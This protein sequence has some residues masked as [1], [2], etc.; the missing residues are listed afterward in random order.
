[1]VLTLLPT[2][3]LADGASG[4]SVFSGSGHEAMVATYTIDNDANVDY[5]ATLAEAVENVKGGGT[6]TL[7]TSVELKEKLVLPE[8][9]TFTLDLGKY[10]I[11][12][13]AG[14]VNAINLAKGGNVTITGTGKITGNYNGV[15]V[16]SGA[17]LTVNGAEIEATVY[18]GI[19]NEGTTIVDSG[20]LT[21]GTDGE[22]Y[23]NGI[24][25]NCGT[26]TV[27]GGTINKIYAENGGTA[28]ITGGTVNGRFYFE[29]TT[30]RVEGGSIKGDMQRGGEDEGITVT[31]G[32]F[33][34]KVFAKS[35]TGGTFN[36]ALTL[37]NYSN[38]KNFQNCTINGS[39]AWNRFSKA[40]M[41]ARAG[42]NIRFGENASVENEHYSINSEL[43][44]ID[45]DYLTLNIYACDGG[46]MEVR[47]DSTTG[48]GKTS[49]KNEKVEAGSKKTVNSA[50]VT[51][52]SGYKFDGWYLNGNKITDGV[53][54]DGSLTDYELTVTENTDLV[55]RFI[56]LDY[57]NKAAIKF[58]DSE[59]TLSSYDDW[60]LFTYA[61]TNL[62]YTF[63]GKTVKLDFT[64]K[65][66]N[67]AGKTY[68]VVGSNEHPFKG[69]FDGNG[70]TITG[71]T[72]TE[73]TTI[74][75]QDL[76]GLFGQ[77]RNATFKNLT[78][79]DC[80]FAGYYAGGIVADAYAGVTI[81]NC[82]IENVA[83]SGWF[84]G[85]V[86]GHTYG[87]LKVRDVTIIGCSAAGTKGGMVTGY[88]E[89][90]T[91]TNVQV[92]DVKAGAA[93]IGHANA[94]ASIIENVRVDAPKAS[95]I[96]MT[97]SESTGT[98]TI[99]GD[100][101]VVKAKSV[102][103]TEKSESKT[104]TI[105]AGTF[106]S[107]DNGTRLDV[108]EYLPANKSQGENG[109]IG[110]QKIYVAEFNGTKYENIE[111]AVAAW[112]DDGGTL[113]LL[114][115]CTSAV[116]GMND[117][118]SK[119]FVLDL[120]GKTLTLSETLKVWRSSLTI[121]DTS[122]AKD[123]KI[124][125]TSGNVIQPDVGGKVIMQAGAVIAEDGIAAMPNNG[126]FEMT[127]G[128][129]QG[130]RSSLDLTK[131]DAQV[132]GGTMIGKINVT[133]G[134]TLTLGAEGETDYTK[135]RVNGAVEIGSGATVNFN[136][137]LV[138]NLTGV[139]NATVSFTE[140]AYFTQNVTVAGYLTTAVTVGNATYYQLTPTCNAAAEVTHE[141]ATTKYAT[142]AA[143][144]IALQDGDTLKLVKDAETAGSY[145]VNA[146]NVTIDLNGFNSAALALNLTPEETSGSV[147]IVNSGETTS[148]ITGAAPLTV[149]TTRTDLAVQV[150]IGKK[151]TL[152]ATDGGDCVTLD[153]G[154]Y[155]LYTEANTGY[156]KNGGFKVKAAE[157][158]ERIY[159]SITAAKS[160]GTTIKLLHDYTASGTL[161]VWGDITLDL[162][163]HTYS[164]AANAFLFEPRED[165]V[166][167]TIMNGTLEGAGSSV[168]GSG[169]DDASL[170]LTNVTIEATG[171]YAI[172]TNGTCTNNTITLTDCTI[173]APNGMGIY[174]PSTGKLTIDGGSITA[175]N[176]V[177]LCAGSLEIKGNATITA[178]GPALADD[179]TF[180]ADGSIEDGAAVS[181]V[182]RSGYGTLGTVKIESGSLAA[183]DGV[184]A[185]QAYT[186]N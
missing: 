127:G 90:V 172:A 156:I 67:F 5:A 48:S 122:E 47:V 176:G 73:N 86:T 153:G 174:F 60:D 78:L 27:N 140:K 26:L 150:T 120:N 87:G 31:G 92:S 93:L 147:K 23:Y 55:A 41:G 167:I 162:N 138:D 97:Y 108:S 183:A 51:A 49:Y 61:V 43:N 70:H 151:V 143:A 179:A 25:S 13:T 152:T 128:T 181:I 18:N 85:T 54:D 12:Q 91:M 39:L 112:K 83:T 38:S 45:T 30:V 76:S 94:G 1:M 125:R 169:F 10:N 135:V 149:T 72:K 21:G 4:A 111:D 17:K 137:C 134:R 117:N 96:G 170:T 119:N 157:S 58:A 166:Q 115:D 28:T 139:E 160:V 131:Y 52:S 9:K 7:Q 44:G 106:T 163:G 6:V 24:Y 68:K 35:V 82:R 142:L 175:K 126:G 114:E 29:W 148:T 69:T 180:G 80:S 132:T 79:K 95:L 66:L 113:K 177:Q 133:S 168:I 185:V 116:S 36:G 165:G 11:T 42:L 89:G 84:S 136:S 16:P 118:Q 107:D 155:L 81:E 64:D 62:G 56:S 158:D 99:T 102:I 14:G 109:Q 110:E 98:I 53:S 77:A 59:V 2:A 100:D 33:D 182:H 75:V 32:T 186:I 146:C 164:T 159:G 8:N 65:L 144:M 15:Y 57:E 173:K 20:T 3:V 129:L 130:S 171:F 34:G 123:G 46:S 124:T 71:I 40:P 19:H 88:S 37:V 101:T 145:N 22:Y 121:T 161:G 74:G 154:A 103:G 178:N 63:E 50:T 105:E 184:D 104:V 141:G